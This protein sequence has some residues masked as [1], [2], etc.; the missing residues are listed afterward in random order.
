MGGF[1]GF[2]PMMGGLGG[3]RSQFPQYQYADSQNGPPQTQLN[4][5]YS[6]MRRRGS[7]DT[8]QNFEPSELNTLTYLARANGIPI[9]PPPDYPGYSEPLSAMASQ[10]ETT[11]ASQKIADRGVDYLKQQLAAKNI[12]FGDSA[13]APY[14]Q[15]VIEDTRRFSRMHNA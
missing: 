13:L 3:F 1:G 10:E 5:L 8:L 9:N 4:Q 12:D 14:R 15:K 7:S 2:D 6:D 11:R